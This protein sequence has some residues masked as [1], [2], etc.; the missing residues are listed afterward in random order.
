MREQYRSEALKAANTGGNAR[1]AEAAAQYQ[2][3]KLDL[4]LLNR[5]RNTLRGYRTDYERRVT[6]K[7]AQEAQLL[8]LQEQ[9][10]ELAA[11]VGT[12]EDQTSGTIL[13]E[14]FRRADAEVRFRVIDPANRPV[15]PITDDQNK[16]MLI[17]V[18]GGLGCGVG[19][20]Y[21]LEFFDHSF[22]SVDEIEAFLGLNV[23]GTIPKIQAADG[24]RVPRG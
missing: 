7:P 24:G 3:A 19:A 11:I 2:V 9:V 16:I 8:K 17:A 5:E 4:D 13:K 12:F 10:N 20:V 18:F 15:T 1:Q 23:L 6:V 22:K 14:E 21:L